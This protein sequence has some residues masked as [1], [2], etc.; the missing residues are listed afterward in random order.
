M[1]QLLVL[2]GKGGTGKTTLAAAFIHLARAKAYADCDIDAPNL[3]LALPPTPPA[4]SEDFLGMEK[5]VIDAERCTACGLCETHCRFS[6][7]LLQQESYTVN[8]MACEGCGVCQWIC[9]A[10]AITMQP[11]KAGV[12]KLYTQSAVF[13][14]GEL[15]MGSGNSG[16]MVT[17]VKQRMQQHA[18]A[19]LAIID[20]S[21]GIGCPVIASMVGV[22]MVLV[23][24]EPSLSG[25]SDLE[26]IVK[27]ARY[28]NVK[29]AVTVNK[30][31][32]APKVTQ[33]IQA[34]CQ[35]EAL[36]M[37]TM[38]P[39]DEKAA[40]ALAQDKTLDATN[41]KAKPYV[42]Q[43]FQETLTLLNNTNH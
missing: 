2:S 26:R 40:K 18:H 17:K 20:G 9:P 28:S 6:A 23:V 12:L 24:T 15:M 41:G 19:E 21:P 37:I 27:T 39:Y 33:K 36:P 43:A 14:T 25:L 32:L 38:I 31:D 11:A 16:K 7:I 8:A 4:Q 3:H 34:Y 1:K 5:A 35:A 22:D 10:K 42:I 13:S 29:L 30:Y